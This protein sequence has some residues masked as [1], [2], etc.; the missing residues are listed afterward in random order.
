MN[1][2]SIFSPQNFA[3]H[4]LRLRDVQM[5]V[6]QDVQTVL[7]AS[8]LE[9]ETVQT[10]NGTVLRKNAVCGMIEAA[11]GTGKTLG[12]LIP[13]LLYQKEH[14]CRIV[15]S[16]F[17]RALQRQLFENDFLL[18]KA[19]TESTATVTLRLGRSNFIQPQRVFDWDARLKTQHPEW[20]TFVTWVRSWTETMDPLNA[21]FQAWH[22]IF[23]DTLVVNG[24]E[25]T[26]DLFAL[27]PEEPH[28]WYEQH[29]T[30]AQNTDIV[31]TNHASLLL[32]RAWNQNFLGDVDT[33]VID[34]ADRLHDAAHSLLSRRIRFRLLVNEYRHE[35]D[36]CKKYL[37]IA[38]QIDADLRELG[39]TMGYKELSLHQ[40]AAQFPELASSIVS[41]IRL[42]DGLWSKRD[43]EMVDRILLELTDP[44]S[45]EGIALSYS[46]IRH[47]PAFVLDPVDVTPWV[48]RIFGAWGEDSIPAKR[49]ILLSAT[50][51]NPLRDTLD[52]AEVEYGIA[53][54]VLRTR[55]EPLH[56]GTMRFVLPDPRVANPF[57]SR[58]TLHYNGEWLD[59][60][61]KALQCVPNKKILMLTPSFSDITALLEH[62]G[63]EPKTQIVHGVLYHQ[64][65]DAKPLALLPG[66]RA[67]ITPSFWEGVNL[68]L[69]GRLWMDELM[70]TR[71]PI[72]PF[73][74]VLRERIVQHRLQRRT[75]EQTRN[76][77]LWESAKTALRKF[78]QGIG[79]GIR[80][81]NDSVRVWLLDPRL[82]PPGDWQSLLL[83]SS[84]EDALEIL[85]AI[86]AI[87][88]PGL[89]HWMRGVP[90][91]FRGA[92][93]EADWFSRDGKLVEIGS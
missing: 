40:L 4:G 69:D 50:L 41:Q 79:R 86:R 59:Y 42:L 19:L 13:V 10:K 3:Q 35:K 27:R 76:D 87:S 78:R 43:K 6:A 64:P 66:I 46:P 71:F 81:E 62:L 45:R 92:L 74:E 39:E 84:V 83:D 1:M 70:I 38:S 58:D 36:F 25:L 56:F 9:H 26:D 2:K 11:T 5:R 90:Q 49:A 18:A 17:T 57:E 22:E 51:F 73:S 21:T 31:I 32:D 88:H 30:N 14:G 80:A 47:F 63:L 23:P 93:V 28:H 85:S 75:A 33:I 8:L 68:V 20:Q 60:I 77:L 7:S 44:V 61:E 54:P 65:D 67:I 48:R 72:P 55:H 16:T 52:F 82:T 24:M 37:E 91:R 89:Q 29:V 15:I 12:Y 34:E 53:R